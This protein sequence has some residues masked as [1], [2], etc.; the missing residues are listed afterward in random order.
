MGGNLFRVYPTNYGKFA[1][2][3]MKK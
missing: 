1:G 3:F 2:A